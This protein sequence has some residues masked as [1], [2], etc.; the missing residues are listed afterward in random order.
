MT[1]INNI[2]NKILQTFSFV[3]QEYFQY[4]IFYLAIFV[5]TIL[6]GL[7]SFH[8]IYQY[9]EKIK[10]PKSL[11]TLYIYRGDVASLYR[12]LIFLFILDGIG[13]FYVIRTIS[14]NKLI[15]VISIFIGVM[16]LFL[17]LKSC[18]FF[19]FKQIPDKLSFFYVFYV[20]GNVLFDNP[21]ATINQTVLGFWLI[22][23]FP[24]KSKIRKS[25]KA[26][27]FEVLAIIILTIIN[28][29]VLLFFFP[30]FFVI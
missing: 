11:L 23:F 21:Y 13:I 29:V 3:R 20:C 10:E 4:I 27:K 1:I 25:Q 19:P 26:T 5:F 8:F 28:M 18:D 30:Q 12:N 6:E 14:I 17:I 15:K 16:F 9:L 22:I 7:N 24:F 2:H